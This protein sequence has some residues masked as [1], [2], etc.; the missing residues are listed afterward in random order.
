MCLLLTVKS[1]T[2]R[3]VT[4]IAVNTISKSK[5]ML[6]KTAVSLDA[7]FLSFFLS[8]MRVMNPNWSAKK[9]LLHLQSVAGIN[10]HSALS[11]AR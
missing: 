1:T 9:Q 10:R 7:R 11:D 8:R 4:V 2:A 3:K 6:E 5:T